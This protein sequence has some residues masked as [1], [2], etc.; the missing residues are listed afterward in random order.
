MLKNGVLGRSEGG[1]H[2]HLLI[3]NRYSHTI[4]FQKSHTIITVYTKLQIAHYIN[5]N[6]EC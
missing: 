2:D 3:L 1:T 4:Q 5:Q 6:P